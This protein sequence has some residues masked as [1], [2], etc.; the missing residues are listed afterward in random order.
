LCLLE[1]RDAEEKRTLLYSEVLAGWID[2][3][4][5]VE[6]SKI[7]EATVT[8]FI[9]LVIPAILLVF[10]LVATYSRTSKSGT[11]KAN[12]KELDSHPAGILPSL[13]LLLHRTALSVSLL[14]VRACTQVVTSCCLK[15]NWFGSK[16]CPVHR[17]P[18]P[19]SLYKD[20]SRCLRFKCLLVQAQC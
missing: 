19:R 11:L 6:V 15:E 5:R 10:F 1:S 17:R 20:A 13:N 4:E 3:E 14:N 18:S 16:I 2:V 12:A 8:V 7:M 9:S